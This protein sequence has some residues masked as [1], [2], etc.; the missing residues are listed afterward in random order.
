MSRR[1]CS[2]DSFWQRIIKKLRVY[3]A[4]ELLTTK[5]SRELLG[6]SL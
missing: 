6:I 3:E 2:A 5:T 1:H 4:R